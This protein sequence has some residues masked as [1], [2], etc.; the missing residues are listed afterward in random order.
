MFVSAKP[1]D[2]ITNNLYYYIPGVGFTFRACDISGSFL[3]IDAG[4]IFRYVW[5]YCS[6][7]DDREFE[8]Q[9]LVHFIC[10]KQFHHGDELAGAKRR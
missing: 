5:A 10:Q 4:E 6:R 8:P 3:I 2:A 1:S 7:G 9:N